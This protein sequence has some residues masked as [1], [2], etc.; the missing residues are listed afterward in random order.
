MTGPS[1]AG[2]WNRKSGSLPSFTRYSTALKSSGLVW[3]D[4][5]LDEWVKDPQHIVPG[6]QMT[7]PGVK[8]SRQRADLLAFLK[9]ATRP[10]GSQRAKKHHPLETKAR[11]ALDLLRTAARSSPM[12]RQSM[13][14]KWMAPS[15]L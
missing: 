1:L 10:D 6:N 15:L 14:T 3:N 11:L 12:C 4:Q 9:E 5:T 7:F 8:D 2:L 13:H